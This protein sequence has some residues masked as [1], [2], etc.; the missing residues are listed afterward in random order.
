MSQVLLDYRDLAGRAYSTAVVL[1]HP[2]VAERG[3]YYD[4]RFGEGGRFTT[5]GD[6]VSQ[7]GLRRVGWHDD[8]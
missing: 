2:H 5:H 6:A 4:V 1:D 7:P 8:A 3:R